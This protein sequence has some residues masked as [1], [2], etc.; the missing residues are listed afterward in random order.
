MHK[1]LHQIVDI[2]LSFLRKEVIS[3]EKNRAMLYT[4]FNDS[5]KKLNVDIEK[6]MHNLIHKGPKYL[7][8]L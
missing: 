6:P 4:C 8:S 2:C 3:D 5:Y 1:T 7:Y